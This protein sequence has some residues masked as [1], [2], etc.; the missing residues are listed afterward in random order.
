MRL[1][2]EL[3]NSV[4]KPIVPKGENVYVVP[5]IAKIIKQES[6]KKPDLEE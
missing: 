6:V 1:E 5:E 4:K 3:A 2:E